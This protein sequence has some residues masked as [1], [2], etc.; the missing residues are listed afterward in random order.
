MAPV[1]LVCIKGLVSI[2]G[3]IP[4]AVSRKQ[5]PP[6]KSEKEFNSNVYSYALLYVNERLHVKATIIHEISETNSSFHV[7]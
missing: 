2:K 4:S 1:I 7:K 3:L 5:S 6:D